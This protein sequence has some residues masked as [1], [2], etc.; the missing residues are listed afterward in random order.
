MSTQK[1][2]GAFTFIELMLV[3]AIVGVFAAMVFPQ[4]GSSINAWRSDRYARSIWGSLKTAQ[5]QAMTRDRPVSVRF[6]MGSGGDV[7][8]FINSNP[9]GTGTWG[10]TLPSLYPIN[11]PEEVQIAS[12]GNQSGDDG[13]LGCIMFHPDGTV[14]R[15]RAVSSGTQGCPSGNPD[16]GRPF[17]LVAPTGMNFDSSNECEF[18][19]IY[20]DESS[21]TPQPYFMDFGAYD[22][23]SSNQ[24]G[25]EPC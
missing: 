22:E 11:L 17:I 6:N 12:V 2:E 10:D 23:F 15:V 16:L 25:D 20:L 5:T 19:T 7:H 21:P 13:G 9:T 3:V 8:F 1:S 14:S 24:L 18:S 4:I